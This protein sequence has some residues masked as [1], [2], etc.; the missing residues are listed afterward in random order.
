MKKIT[1]VSLFIICLTAQVSLASTPQ[2]YPEKT[3]FFIREITPFT[4]VCIPH[5]GSFSDMERVSGILASSIQSQDI[6]LIGNI[7]GI[8]YNSL[9]TSQPGE[10]IWE[11]GFPVDPEAMPQ[12]PLEKKQWNFTT[13]LTGLHFG[14][15]TESNQTINK[16]K[17]WMKVNNYV[18][19]GPILEKYLDVNPSSPMPGGLRIEIWI[20]CKESEEIVFLKV[21]DQLADV[22]SGPNPGYSVLAQLKMGALVELSGKFGD[23]Y[24][25]IFLDQDGQ[26]V[27]GFIDRKVV[28]IVSGEEAKGEVTEYFPQKKEE[29]I[30]EERLRIEE[31]PKTEKRPKTVKTKSVISALKALK[32]MYL[33]FGF[34]YS[35]RNSYNRGLL[36][37]WFIE[38]TGDPSRLVDQGSPA[39]FSVSGTLF[40]DISNNL[41]LGVGTDVLISSPHAL[42]GTQI[43]WGG[44]QEIVLSP[45]IMAIKMP[46]R[47]KIGG[48]GMMM[49]VT[50]S[51]ALLMGW[52]TG[53]YDDS[54]SSTYWEFKPSSKMGFGMSGGI[55]MFFGKSLGMGMNMGWRSLTVGLSFENPSSETGFSTPLMSSGAPVTVDLGG[56]YITTG[57]LFRF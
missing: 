45:F 53:T 16:M 10:L 31:E 2:E 23:F 24:E 22:R 54:G 28:E 14:P 38:R 49:S 3:S 48:M 26:P 29:V 4:Y 34:Y 20:P 51:P 6:L 33:E 47:M 25:I 8:Y 7:L 44:S 39:F 52:V 43:Y 5:K 56:T 30:I 35:M 50:A 11:V 36:D 27:Q 37:E 12:K 17:E 18:S 13:V 42:W 40:M 32:K 55:E 19:D 9:E 15:Y 21:K 41:S 46:L 1:I 57:L